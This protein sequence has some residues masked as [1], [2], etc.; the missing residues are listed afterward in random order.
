MSQPAIDLNPLG[1]YTQ[2]DGFAIDADDI[3]LAPSRYRCCHTSVTAAG[4]LQLQTLSRPQLAIVTIR[5]ELDEQLTVIAD[6][7]AMEQVA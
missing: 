7:Q 1:T 3:A 6:R 4:A 5:M 2:R